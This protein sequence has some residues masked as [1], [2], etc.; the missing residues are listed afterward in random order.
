MLLW[1]IKTG[2]IPFEEFSQEQLRTKLLTEKLRPWVPEDV[3]QSL[4]LLIRRCWQ[5]KV[6]NRP[7]FPEI[8]DK[9][10]KVSFN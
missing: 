10:R 3:C 8:L 9:L 6:S 2:E 4:S 7:G 5:N 1:E